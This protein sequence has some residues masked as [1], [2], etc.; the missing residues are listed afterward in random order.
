MALVAL[1]L[2]SFSSI[3]QRMDFVTEV[4]LKDRSIQQIL[5]LAETAN[6]SMLRTSMWQAAGV[7][8]KRIA[9]LAAK[10]L[11]TLDQALPLIAA[12][13]PADT[14]TATADT[15]SLA[16][17][18]DRYR[19]SVADAFDLIDDPASASGYYRAADNAYQIIRTDLE[20]RLRHS[21]Q[22]ESSSIT[23]VQQAISAA[24]VQLGT[25]TLLTVLVTTLM[26]V[27]VLRGILLAI[28]RVTSGM[29]SLTDGDYTSALPQATSRDE[30]GTMI[31][32]LRIF[33]DR[34]SAG[35]HLRQE[36]EQNAATHA[37]QMRAQREAIADRFQQRM[38]A[39]ANAFVQSADQVSEAARTLAET[40]E[41]TF[42]Q[43]NIGVT[44]VQ[45]ASDNVETVSASMAQFSASVHAISEQ[46][47]QSG[48]VMEQ[49]AR[50]AELTQQNIEGL[51]EAA[52]QIGEVVNLIRSIA[53]QT[54]LLALNAT[55]EAARAGE[56]GKGFAVVAGEVKQLSLETADATERIASKVGEIQA[57]T[58]QAVSAISHIVGTVGTMHHSS[59]AI[60]ASVGDQREVATAISDS[61][62][63]ASGSI[64]RV[65]SSVDGIGNAARRTGQA[66]SELLSLASSLERQAHDVQQEVAAFI[67]TLRED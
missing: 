42:L 16:T 30:I 23:A 7:E 64:T 38:G 21:S 5:D 35:E 19:K 26:S 47:R 15:Q 51:A 66:S 40:A 4:A 34:L 12:L 57:A 52:Y 46:A 65:S 41:D 62:L 39:L 25:V 6:A 37:G 36:Q 9:D 13:P 44:A 10:T 59:R 24:T 28:Q 20:E 63:G 17:K 8:E 48:I 29:R 67:A 61:A 22:Q 49:A 56:T 3:G 14:A 11:S 18:Y 45:E 55:I 1:A 31:E 2:N 27:V 60:S 33:R 32:T 58:G 54:N 43:T 53:G 50:E